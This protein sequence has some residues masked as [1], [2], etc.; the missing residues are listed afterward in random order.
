MLQS[1]I[2]TEIKEP[3][4]LR[5]GLWEVRKS[6]TIPQERFKRIYNITIHKDAQTASLINVHNKKLFIEDGPKRI[7]IDATSSILNITNNRTDIG[8][9]LNNKSILENI[10]EH[11]HNED[12][13][14]EYWDYAE[15]EQCLDCGYR[16]E[17]EYIKDAHIC[18]HINFKTEEEAINNQHIKL[19][20]LY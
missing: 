4:L 14:I 20:T 2:I 11:A 16:T 10:E 17:E 1:E 18:A 15:Y 19:F 5:Y 12:A 8:L 3:A 6:I 13:R 7:S 9:Y